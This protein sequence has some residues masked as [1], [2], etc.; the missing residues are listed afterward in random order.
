A[1]AYEAEKALGKAEAHLE[2][3]LMLEHDHFLANLGLAALLMRRGSP[4][5]MARA[6]QLLDAAQKALGPAPL[7]AERRTLDA[8][9]PSWLLFEGRD[10]EARQVVARLLVTRREGVERSLL[11]QGRRRPGH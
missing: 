1:K 4:A 2:A 11:L 10:L 3:A 8:L 5:E 6:G 9:R 7:P